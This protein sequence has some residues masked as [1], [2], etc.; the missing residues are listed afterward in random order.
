MP[1]YQVSP[2]FGGDCQ[3]RNQGRRHRFHHHPHHHGPPPPPHMRHVSGRRGPRSMMPANKD[4][5]E[6]PSEESKCAESNSFSDSNQHP[7][8]KHHHHHHGPPPPPPHMRGPMFGR[9]G[10]RFSNVPRKSPEETKTEQ[11]EGS[12]SPEHDGNL[13]IPFW[14][15]GPH[16]HSS[17][18]AGPSH[19]HRRHRHRHRNHHLHKK[20][21]LLSLLQGQQHAMDKFEQSHNNGS[22]NFKSGAARKT[23]HPAP[24]SAPPS[25][26]TIMQ[27]PQQW[28]VEETETSLI[29]SIDVAGF[30]LEDLELKV[31]HGVLALFGQRIN[32]L[33]DI[34]ELNRTKMLDPTMFDEAGIEARCDNQED[35][36]TSILSITIPKKEYI[37]Q[38]DT[39]PIRRRVS[40]ESNPE[41]LEPATTVV[42]AIPSEKDL[43][44][45][46]S[47]DRLEESI[48]FV[49]EA[50]IIEEESLDQV[51]VETVDEDSVE[52]ASIARE[53]LPRSATTS[54]S[55][56]SSDT[57][58]SWEDL[59]MD[60]KE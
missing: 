18:P 55:V 25:A 28:H 16:R 59:N 12:K 10:R 20:M 41:D 24:P 50:E 8:H 56:T 17:P 27:V 11:P 19:F 44:E 52:D 9:R 58:Q 23:S 51:Q 2:G 32:S 35:G 39:I 36:A 21:M 47:S 37:R 40:E 13:H 15:N 49:P 1:F 43:T 30:R 46:T 6:S 22:E 57:T 33:G 5:N 29:V 14:G 54:Q 45:N 42:T 34:F 3:V 7:H 38:Q 53:Q 60:G 4:T 48:V 31:E 26:P